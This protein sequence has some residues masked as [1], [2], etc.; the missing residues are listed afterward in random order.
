MYVC[1]VVYKLQTSYLCGLNIK[2][3]LLY[4]DGPLEDRK[5][6]CEYKDTIEPISRCSLTIS[7][8]IKFT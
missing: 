2:N 8:K 4:K 5:I 1:Y 3:C 7:L 6:F